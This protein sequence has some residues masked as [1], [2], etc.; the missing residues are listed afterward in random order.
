MDHFTKSKMKKLLCTLGILFILF[1]LP[2][3]FAVARD[4]EF[5]TSDKSVVVRITDE[6][7]QNPK[8]LETLSKAYPEI[9]PYFFEGLVIEDG[10]MSDS[11][12]IEYKGLIHVIGADWQ[13]PGIPLPYFKDRFL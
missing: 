10:K 3:S 4:M 7:C 11:C 13:Y 12:W 1:V 2:L 5:S 9:L 6:K 8:I